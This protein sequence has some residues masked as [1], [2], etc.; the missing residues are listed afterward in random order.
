MKGP[1]AS[2]QRD[3]QVKSQLLKRTLEKPDI[4][5]R[6]EHDFRTAGNAQYYDRAFDY[7]REVLDPTGNPTVLDAGCGVCAHAMRL[8]CRGFDVVAVDFSPSVLRSA[9]ANLERSGFSDRIRLACQDILSLPFE[10]ESFDHVLCWGVLMHIP[11]A[12]TAVREIARVVRPGGRIVVSEGNMFSLESAVQRA[13]RRALRKKRTDVRRT[14]AGLEHWV[15]SSTGTLMTRQADIGW[16]IDRFDS[17]GLSLERRVAGQ[18]TETFTRTSSPR[19]KRWIHRFN[20]F[21][22]DRIKIAGPAFG[23]ILT[24]RK[25]PRWLDDRPEAE[26]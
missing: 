24:F 25:R 7:I 23:N 1:A 6:W 21:W 15:R 20:Y 17:V 16:L 26:S 3:I 18:F 19:L 10:D 9:R 2:Y 14:A 13:V 4:H 12:E 22:F 11:D 5:E 8:V